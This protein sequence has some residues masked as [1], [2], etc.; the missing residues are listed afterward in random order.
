MGDGT[1]TWLVTYS[2]ESF[3]DEIFCYFATDKT[4][5]VYYVIP[6]FG[7]ANMTS[8]NNL[9]HFFVISSIG[10]YFT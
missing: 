2:R 6:K 10:C 8:L 1:G 4:G 7:F 9:S 3:S 5:F